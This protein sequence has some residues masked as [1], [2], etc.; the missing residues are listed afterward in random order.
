MRITPENMTNED[1]D[2]KSIFVFGSN[3]GGVHGAG[4]AHFAMSLGASM[5]QGF[6]QSGNTFA[7]PTKDWTMQQL[8]LQTIKFYV[9]R[10]IVYAKEMGN[11]YPS[12]FKDVKFYVTKIGCG[13]AGYTPEDIAPLFAECIDMENVYLPQEF[14]DIINSE[15]EVTVSHAN[16]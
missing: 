4:A 14:I 10:F 2:N 6:G 16:I 7:I 11:R 9:D 15:K 5:G 3:E 8:D 12:L 13:L 1:I